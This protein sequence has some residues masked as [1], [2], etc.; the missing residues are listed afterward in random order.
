MI[1]QPT[2]GVLLSLVA[3]YF[4]EGTLGFSLVKINNHFPEKKALARDRVD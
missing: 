1:V 4:T 3:H 2:K